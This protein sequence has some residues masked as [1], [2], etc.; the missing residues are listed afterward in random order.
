MVSVVF[1]CLSSGQTL[2]TKQ[3]VNDTTKVV[4]QVTVCGILCVPN[5]GYNYCQNRLASVVPK[6]KVSPPRPKIRT[7]VNYNEDFVNFRY[8]HCYSCYAAAAL[9]STAICFEIWSNI[10]DDV[11]Y[12]IS[13][14]KDSSD[15]NLASTNYEKEES[16]KSADRQDMKRKASMLKRSVFSYPV[17]GRN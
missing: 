10:K 7:Y 17:E 5:G 12:Y 14:P 1:R 16:S 6:E 3:L 15:S 2:C 13:P 11:L 4:P 9:V 8:K